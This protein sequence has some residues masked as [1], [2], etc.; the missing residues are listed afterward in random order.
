MRIA[1]IVISL[2]L[3]CI[4]IHGADSLNAIRIGYYDTGGIAK[5]IVVEGGDAYV[6]DSYS[7]FLVLDISDPS[8]PT[9][10]A[11]YNTPGD[12]N[13]LSISDNNLYLADMSGGV[14]IFDISNPSS[15]VQISRDTLYA[16]YTD[17]S[18]LGEYARCTLGWSGFS[19]LNFSD[20]ADPE[21]H[22]H[23]TSLGGYAYA[24]HIE[25][26]LAYLACGAG[27]LKIIDLE[28]PALIGSY[29]ISGSARGVFAR[30]DTVF[31]AAY[32]GGLIILDA[33]DPSAPELIGAFD[34]DGYAHGVWVAETL[35]FVAD[36]HEGLRIIN[37]ADPAS[38]FETGYYKTIH[39]A[40]DVTEDNG[41]VYAAFGND[42]VYILDVG[43]I[44][45]APPVLD[46]VWFS[47]ET[48]CDGVDLVHI[49]YS[50]SDAE[51]DPADISV[52]MSGN[53]GATWD[54]P[55][56]TLYNTFGNIGAD[57][58]PGV[59][60]FDW[61]MSAD[62]PD[63]E[64]LDWIVR[65]E[66]TNPDLLHT[67]VRGKS[68]PY[69]AGM[70]VGTQIT[71]W[72][73]GDTIPNVS[74]VAI[75]IESDIDSVAIAAVGSVSYGVD[76]PFHSP[77]GGSPTPTI[78]EYEAMSGISYF[79]NAPIAGLMAVFIGD[80]PPDPENTPPR[81][82]AQTSTPMLQQTVFIG[83]GPFT[84][85][86]PEGAARLFLGANDHYRWQDNRGHFDIDIE[87]FTDESYISATDTAP[88]DSSPPAVDIS[89]PFETLTGGRIYNFSWSVDDLFYSDNE[90]SVA[91]T[92][93]AFEEN[94]AATGPDFGWL[95]PNVSV[96]AC[97]MIVAARDSFCNWGHDTCVFEIAEAMLP[98]SAWVDT[99]W[100]AEEIDCDGRNI[101]EI[102][103][104]LASTCPDSAFSTSIHIS[105][106]SGGTWG[107]DIDSIWE[108]DGDIGE[109][110][111]P[112]T[113]CFFWEFGRDLPD[114]EGS[115]WLIEVGV[116]VNFDTFMV[117]DSFDIS[118]RPNYGR[119]L[120][121]GDGYYWVYDLNAGFIYKTPCI[122]CPPEDS[123]HVGENNN[124]DID[125][126]DGYIYFADSS[127]GDC[128]RIHRIDA[129]TH[130]QEYIATLP[131][132]ASDI[133]GVQV[134]GDSL[135]VAW[136]GIPEDNDSNKVLYLDLTDPF[137][138][139]SW[140]TILTG[141]VDDCHTI[142]GMTF[143]KGS[144]WG[145]NDFGRIV[146]IDLEIPDYIGCYPVPNIG[147]GAE[148]LCWDGEFMWYHNYHGTGTMKIYKIQLWDSFTNSFTAAGPL[149]SRPPNITISCPAES[150]NIDEPYMF[151]WVFD[152]DF[153]ADY[154]CS[155]H[156]FGCGMVQHHY[157]ADTHV[158]WTPTAACESCSIIIVAR[159]SF[160][161]WGTDT[162]VF[163][164]FEE[165]EACSVDIDSVWFTEEV[166]CDG[167]NVMIIC[168]EFSS[169]CP[170][171]EY[172]VTL[173]MS[174]NS[175]GSWSVP[176]DSAWDSEGDLGAGVT[177]GIHCF[178]WEMGCDLP[179]WDGDDFRVRVDVTGH[180]TS[181]FYIASGIADSRGPRIDIACPE[182]TLLPLIPYTYHWSIEEPFLADYPCSVTISGCGILERHEIAGTSIS[183]TAPWP[184]S[185]YVLTVATHDSFCNLGADTCYFTIED[186]VVPCS[187]WVD[188]FWFFEETDCDDGNTIEICYDLISTC[189]DSAYSVSILASSDYGESW[190]VPLASLTEWEGDLGD[191]IFAGNHCFY[192]DIG[193]DLPDWEGELSLE[194]TLE[195]SASGPILDISTT[196]GPADTKA[197]RLTLNCPGDSVFYPGDTIHLSWSLADLF[198][199]SG[200]F[201]LNIDWCVGET[202]LSI[203]STGFDWE[204][205]F[206]AGGCDE[207][208][209]TI[210]ARDSFCNWGRDSC[211][212]SPDTI[213]LRCNILIFSNAPDG[214]T[215]TIDSFDSLRAILED[216]GNTVTTVGA[217]D[218][219][220]LTSAYLADFNQLWF[221][222]SKNSL[223]TTLSP[224][225]ILAIRNFAGAGRGLAIL[226]DHY[227][228][229]AIDANYILDE[230]GVLLDGSANHRPSGLC[231]DEI[232]F[233]SHPITDDLTELACFTSESR[234]HNSGPDIFTPLSEYGGDTLQAA[235][236][237]SGKRAFID[238]SYYRY[239]NPYVRSCGGV[240]LVENISCWL[241]PG[242]CGCEIDS[243]TL[244]ALAFVEDPQVCPGDSVTLQCSISGET[245]AVYFQWW[246]L[247]VGFSSTMQNPNSGPLF[248]DTWFFVRAYESADCEDIDSVFIDV[249]ADE[250][251]DTFMCLGD[252]MTF[253]TS[254][255][256]DSFD[257]GRA[258]GGN[259][260]VTRDGIPQLGC[261]I[262]S[263]DSTCMDFIP[264]ET[265][266][267]WV[268]QE[269]YYDGVH[270]C[271]YDVCWFVTVCC[272][273]FGELTVDSLGACEWALYFEHFADSG[274]AE[275]DSV[276][277]EI[278]SFRELPFDTTHIPGGIE[279]GLSGSDSVEI[280][281]MALTGCVPP[282]S[283]IFE[284]CTALTCIGEDCCE[285][286]VI[287]IPDSVCFG[288]SAALCAY[289]IA[290]SCPDIDTLTCEWTMD[291]SPVGT[292][293]CVTVFPDTASVYCVDVSYTSAFGELCIYHSCA[294]AHVIPPP[295]GDIWPGTA[296]LGLGDTLVLPVPCGAYGDGYL[297]PDSIV[298]L[299]GTT[300]LVETSGVFAPG[301]WC[302]LR[303][304]ANFASPPNRVFC[305][306]MYLG[307]CA[308]L[309]IECCTLTV[310]DTPHAEIA[311][312]EGVCPE[313]GYVD[314]C[315]LNREPSIS[316][317]RITWS[318]GATSICT[319]IPLEPVGTPCGGVNGF[320]PETVSVEICHECGGAFACITDTY[321]IYPE[322][323]FWIDILPSGVTQG[324]SVDTEPHI[325]PAPSTDI[326][327][328]LN[329]YICQGDTMLIYR[330]ESR[331]PDGIHGATSLFEKTV[332]CAKFDYDFGGGRC[333]LTACDSVFVRDTLITI[334][335]TPC[336]VDSNGFGDPD[337]YIEVDD[338]RRYGECSFTFP[339]DSGC[340]TIC[341]SDTDF[342]MPRVFIFDHWESGGAIYSHASCTTYCPS[343]AFDTIFAVYDTATICMG[344]SPAGE[345]IEIE[346]EQILL[347][348]DSVFS[349]FNI[350]EPRG[351]SLD[352][353]G[354]CSLSVQARWVSSANE[355]G[356][357]CPAIQLTN[358]A[359]PGF[360]RLGLRGIITPDSLPSDFAVL[361]DYFIDIHD[362]AHGPLGPGENQFLYIGVVSPEDFHRCYPDGTD[363]AYR[364]TLRLRWGIY[365]P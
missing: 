252:T 97:T 5:E 6:A 170:D 259:I 15:P 332:F 219:I 218:G 44:L 88:L 216:M 169:T 278:T 153:L 263:E 158:S 112:G 244:E 54:V 55:L 251:L 137:P 205:P 258:G 140:D 235:I 67:R 331:Y 77:E 27:G 348:N 341:A 265:G 202:T 117:I 194:I 148:G 292:G 270:D 107:D 364:I 226:A 71:D 295:P 245:G 277:W 333:E 274:C 102:C 89:C 125:Y 30:N 60:C 347:D 257:S 177:E 193:R 324:D 53:G 61:D 105:S 7:G 106:D 239:L 248:E 2:L 243:C 37:I 210:E 290:D 94:Y 25:N 178:F 62:L 58:I 113:H 68:C 260:T 234:I 289:F 109:G 70:P 224:S 329:W 126:K 100:F 4:G 183:W 300:A 305:Y 142:E 159:D 91:F 64:A 12:A 184:C 151:Q 144:L 342:V 73:G 191:S 255:L 90:C 133:E 294:T 49:C 10:R 267:Y 50:L 308:W 214:A 79:E 164:V 31:I 301:D 186:E 283:C 266:D 272:K 181:D 114:M 141:A 115:D 162:C 59:H 264:L 285:L 358:H 161:N 168:Y 335:K 167:R 297:I 322:Y 236:S 345:E 310:C 250:E 65:I 197:P 346:I 98:C 291:G 34:T 355:S 20:P 325:L 155:V 299:T 24:I 103:Y 222:D 232:F 196:T 45:N 146:E 127:G 76:Y 212:V 48:D 240:T 136:Y 242:G 296:A 75:N 334:I 317:D 284:A 228:Y 8:N 35:A 150:L 246:S 69:F 130:A 220:E 262:M 1:N 84:L 129:A 11:V 233:D 46:S 201:S 223:D 206:G 139:S 279:I 339:V 356:F 207:I 95:V 99:V 363:I 179:G 92:S 189:P 337:G 241:E 311:L 9:N 56:N 121:H 362:P 185:S 171:S 328:F 316:I 51:G 156:I 303:Y 122:G 182:D 13:D 353:C 268:C 293:S 253:C 160:C 327:S 96:P 282:S 16:T 42:G 74:A 82:S 340:V 319:E 237:G 336:G 176:M 338:Y 330:G 22:W 352:N 190:A 17:V 41:Y 188:T 138:I 200:P 47:E 256:C 165:E 304:P 321:I 157:I 175:G 124:C 315:V 217:S 313:L 172:Y 72:W 281:V 280:C 365:L 145:C 314:V 135:I 40:L 149:D 318:N 302:V 357:D 247:P 323:S 163:V 230:W 221:I 66:L 203:D 238:V 276:V 3:F 43:L 87:I 19:I 132:Y 52:S 187:A 83:S 86:P 306:D 78:P 199:H 166:Y 229:F 211:F 309:Q 180:E 213:E 326:D 261:L 85:I 350:G 354:S 231:N 26:E 80:N 111:L 286:E 344:L 208:W 215:Y 361:K 152:D 119:G 33:T 154:P 128:K 63:S 134:V 147:E 110:V 254:A 104:D 38:P 173:I 307:D 195:N 23:S 275:I 101:V 312:P 36:Y 287:S 39:N 28:P 120:A 351:F 320:A 359:I 29:P 204:I 343:G 32:T 123:F 21:E 192:W 288:E 118:D 360:N 93:P 81:L 116:L 249:L 18:G 174:S 298:V 57:V 131:E 143:A 349:H 14:R 227:P 273:P 209:F 271:C 269:D 225:E 198:P 108:D